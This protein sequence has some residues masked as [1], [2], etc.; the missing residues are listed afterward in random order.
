MI[1]QFAAQSFA[2]NWW[3]QARCIFVQAERGSRK[4]QGARSAI[5][6]R[7]ETV[8][9]ANHGS[10]GLGLDVNPLILYRGHCRN[11]FQ[12]KIERIHIRCYHT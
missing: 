4:A 8:L 6:T 3:S 7:Y 9:Y 12:E 5:G 10:P 1:G 11:R 2:S